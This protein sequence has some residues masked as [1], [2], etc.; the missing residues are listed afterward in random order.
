MKQDLARYEDWSFYDTYTKTMGYADIEALKVLNML[1]GVVQGVLDIV[2]ILSI[3]VTLDVFVLVMIAVMIVVTFVD[4][5][6]SDKLMMKKYDVESTIN[7]Q[8]DYI[9]KVA[10]FKQYASEIRT[11][12]L[13]KFLL[14]KLDDMFVKKYDLFKSTHRKYWRLKYFAFLILRRNT[15]CHTRRAGCT[16]AART[17]L[18]CVHRLC[19]PDTWAK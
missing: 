6:F 3:V 8:T 18:R 9:K 2:A 14:R 1:F 13:H 12:G 10:H 17:Y 11:Y 19:T 7:R 4:Q 5:Y 16:R 15:V